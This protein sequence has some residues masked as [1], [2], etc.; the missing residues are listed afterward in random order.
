MGERLKGKRVVVTQC[1]DYMGPATCDLF[2]REGAEVIADRR[3][4]REPGAAQALI[5]EAGHVDILVAN[6]AA[7]QNAWCPP[8]E[9]GLELWNHVF[10]MMVHPLFRLCRAVLPQMY[11]RGKGKIVVYG[12][13]SA[14]R[15]VGDMTAYAAARSAQHGYVRQIAGEAAEHGVQVNVIAQGFTRNPTYFPESFQKTELFAK[16]IADCPMGR[17]AE[18][19]EDAEV[20]LF[21]ASDE[22]DFL[23]GV[24]LPFVGG[25]QL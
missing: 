24:E 17:L 15:H 21:L 12:S 22:S 9:T 20:A 3:D 13:A 11:A 25:W 5:D 19:E 14:L 1:D 23:V 18:G 8:L 4:L 2:A 6:L 10:D 7:T 16:L